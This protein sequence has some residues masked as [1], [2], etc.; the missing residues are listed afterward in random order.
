VAKNLGKKRQSALGTKKPQE[1]VF[2]QNVAS[3]GAATTASSHLEEQSLVYNASLFSPALAG[4]LVSAGL[5]LPASDDVPT[6]SLSPS[7]RSETVTASSDRSCLRDEQQARDTLQRQWSQF[8][9]A[10]KANC[11]R[12]E[13]S[14]G[15][16]SYV[17]LLT[18]LQMAAA[19][20]KLPND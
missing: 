17:E 11:M 4:A 10:D 18:C 16:P 13:E 12:V 15:A 14:A 6:Y 20:K 2:A 8:A 7:C 5:L 19:A 3:S 1:L 9:P